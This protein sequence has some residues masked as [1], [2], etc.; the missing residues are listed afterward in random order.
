MFHSLCLTPQ[1]ICLRGILEL[2]EETLLCQGHLPHGGAAVFLVLNIPSGH[3][4][5][6]PST[7]DGM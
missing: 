2:S 6:A 1:L 4:A 5:L 7:L 3:F